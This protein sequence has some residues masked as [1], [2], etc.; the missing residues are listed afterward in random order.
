M[1]RYGW[2]GVEIAS[3][4]H[5]TDEKGLIRSEDIQTVEDMYRDLTSRMLLRLTSSCGTHVP[6]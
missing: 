5:Y 4:V 6:Y 3:S 1:A 2:L